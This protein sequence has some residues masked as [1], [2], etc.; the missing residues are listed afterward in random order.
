[1]ARTKKAPKS[2]VFPISLQKS[3]T[4]TKFKGKLYCHFA[5]QFS[6]KTITF[7]SKELQKPKK[8]LPAIVDMI[9]TLQS[10][11]K[12]HG[13]DSEDPNDSPYNTSVESNSSESE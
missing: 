2:K 10:K 3:A 6:K 9:K 5:D 11:K 4:V 13:S 8:V 7:D 1:M 12:H